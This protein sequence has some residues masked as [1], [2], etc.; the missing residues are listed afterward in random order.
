M[1]YVVTGAGNV[2]SCGRCVT[3]TATQSHFTDTGTNSTPHGN[4]GNVNYTGESDL[5]L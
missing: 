5:Y 2:I 4:G 1:I 3:L